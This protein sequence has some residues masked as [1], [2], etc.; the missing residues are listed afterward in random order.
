M[1]AASGDHGLLATW[2]MKQGYKIFRNSFYHIVNSEKGPFLTLDSFYKNSED[3]KYELLDELNSIYDNQEL[4][5]KMLDEYYMLKELLP[6][7][8]NTEAIDYAVGEFL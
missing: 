5:N 6:S 8:V 7:I 3:L 4:I 1:P 2:L